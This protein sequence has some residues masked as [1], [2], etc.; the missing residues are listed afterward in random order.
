MKRRIF[1]KAISTTSLLSIINP[2]GL[3][4]DLI[5]EEEVM[6][7]FID[8][9]RKVSKLQ[10]TPNAAELY[11][12]NYYCDYSYDAMAPYREWYAYQQA[13]AVWEQQMMYWMQQ[14]QYYAWLKQFYIQKMKQLLYVYRGHM[15][16]GLPQIWDHIESIYGYARDKYGQPILFG[17]NQ[18]QNNVAVKDN[19]I[20]ASKIF[21]TISNYYGLNEAQKT[22]GPQSTEVPAA[23]EFGNNFLFGKKY[24]T[25]N[26]LLAVSNPNQLVRAD[27]G[28]VG[29]LAKYVTGPDGEKYGV[30]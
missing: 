5:P 14:E 7:P 17:L 20:G 21:Y 4:D 22:V 29:R 3:F 9:I 12:H 19:L 2:L 16:I 6:L 25:E 1:L 30:V 18:Y 8:G 23:I 11:A 26:G 13:L 10:L 27:N 15:Q 28:K 24:D